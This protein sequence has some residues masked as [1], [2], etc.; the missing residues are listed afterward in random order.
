MVSLEPFEVPGFAPT[1]TTKTLIA[2]INIAAFLAQGNPFVWNQLLYIV[3]G[4]APQ[5]TT[6]TFKDASAYPD[7]VIVQAL[8]D[9]NFI[10]NLPNFT[11]E[12]Q[13]LVTDQFL[14][15]NTIP[16]L[17]EWGLIVLGIILLAVGVVFI[18][19]KKRLMNA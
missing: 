6:I 11:G 10:M 7:S 9:T 1:D 18:I 19:R 16:T 8:A 15:P 2:D 13:V 12:V 5:T 17:S 3:N 4:A 14:P